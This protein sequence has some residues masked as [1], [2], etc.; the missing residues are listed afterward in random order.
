L[1]KARRKPRKNASK[2]PR[3]PKHNITKNGF[4][5]KKNLEMS[6]APIRRDNKDLMTE[7]QI[8]Q[9][10]KKLMMQLSSF[11]RQQEA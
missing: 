3:R 11:D 9:N 5:Y 1:I 7:E 10:S 8:A 6:S 2:N 4:S